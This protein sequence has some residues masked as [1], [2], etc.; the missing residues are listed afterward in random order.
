MN[1]S[2]EYVIQ[3]L[4]MKYIFWLHVRFISL[5]VIFG[6]IQGNEYIN[7]LKCSDRVAAFDI[8]KSTE[9]NK[10]YFPNPAKS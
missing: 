1:A 8:G 5:F 9:A 3:A 10:S 2:V 7:L 6:N 4:K